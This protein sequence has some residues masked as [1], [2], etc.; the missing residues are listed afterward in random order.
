MRVNRLLEMVS[1]L[2]NRGTI[3]AREFADRFEVSIRTV[4]RD[5][6]DLSSAGVPVYMSKGRGGGISLLENYTFDRALVTREETDSLL[7]SLKTLQATQYPEIDRFLEKLG[8]IFQ[9]STSA[10]WVHIEFSPWGSKPNEEG[11]F[12]TIKHSILNSRVTHFDYVNSQGDTSCRNV[13]PMRLIFKSDAWYLWGFCRTRQEYR[14]FRLSRIKNLIDTGES[15]IRREEPPEDNTQ[16][17]ILTHP[18]VPIKLRFFPPVL[19]RV[20]DD[21][22]DSLIQKNPDGSCEVNISMP[23]DDWLTGFILSYGNQVKVLDPPELCESIIKQLKKTL[24][25]YS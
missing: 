7:L 5:V 9:Q 12:V 4:Y 25:Q 14:T 8:A 3:P 13:E 11:K 2:L 18:F 21:F 23:L 15:F 6:E 20:Y 24:V 22:D 16:N 19:H 1:L 17:Q 10:D